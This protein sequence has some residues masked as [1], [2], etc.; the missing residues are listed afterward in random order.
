MSYSEKHKF[1]FGKLI[2]LRLKPPF[3]PAVKSFDKFLKIENPFINFVKEDN[4]AK[5]NGKDNKQNKDNY[6]PPDYDPDWVDE[7]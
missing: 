6:I 5:N 4:I 7:F 3:K 2:D 1:D